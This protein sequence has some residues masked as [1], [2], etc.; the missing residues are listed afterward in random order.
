MKPSN[1]ELILDYLSGR[2]SEESRREFETALTKDASLAE[3]LEVQKAVLSVIDQAGDIELKSR[4]GQILPKYKA[5]T[6]TAEQTPPPP[7][8]RRRFLGWVGAAAAAVLLLFVLGPGSNL[9]GGASAPDLFSQ[10]YEAY[11]LPFGVR[12]NPNN[13]DSTIQEATSFYQKGNY[14]AA[15]PLFTEIIQQ[16]AETKYQ[17]ALGICQ[18]ETQQYRPAIQSFSRLINPADLIYGEQAIWYT[19]MAHLALDEAAAAQ[20]LLQQLA[21][22]PNAFK[23]ETARELLKEKIK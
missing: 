20:P 2:L 9:F 1:Q 17:L 4:L 23:S 13:I 11:E 8:A 3:E 14:A 15:L 6:G 12:G 18:M 19:A 10:N 7:Q 22:N 16:S 21:A 5:P